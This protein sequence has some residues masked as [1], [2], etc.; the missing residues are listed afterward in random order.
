MLLQCV[1]SLWVLL[2]CLLCCTVL[3]P[4]VWHCVTWI[5]VSHEARHFSAP[6]PFSVPA[7]V[8]LTYRFV[9]Q[10]AIS[11]IRIDGR[12]HE[13]GEG[14]SH[15]CIWGEGRGLISE[16]VCKEHGGWFLLALE[17]GL[18]QR[19]DWL[20]VKLR[21]GRQLDGPPSRMD[22]LQKHACTF[23]KSWLGLA[24]L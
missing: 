23:Q 24:G 14:L 10:P 12:Y 16:W 5:S 9:K 3:V 17:M 19:S 7:T 8:L 4:F 15:L 11:P 2:S 6:Y 20:S 1:Y 21:C 22:T 13:Y 18:G